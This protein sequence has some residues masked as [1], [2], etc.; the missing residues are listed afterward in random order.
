M[1]MFPNLACNAKDIPEV[2]AYINESIRSELIIAGIHV[3]PLKGPQFELTEVP[4]SMV[5]VLTHKNE[6]LEEF[7]NFTKR[8][9]D[10]KTIEG[11]DKY[12]EFVFVRRWYYWSVKGYVP[13]KVAQEIYA[14]SVG[15]RA[16]RAGG[17][18]ACRPPE[19]WIEKHYV[20]GQDVVSSYHIDNQEGLNLFVETV[21][22]HN[23]IKGVV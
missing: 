1:T 10:S 8:F 23:L 2:P 11:W 13:L 18:C 16:V 7:V 4:Y 3:V 22:K 5:G 6:R 21:K 15:R 19:T 9:S 14:D 17:D 12:F 20:A